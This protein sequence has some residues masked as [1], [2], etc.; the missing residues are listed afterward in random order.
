MFWITSVGAGHVL[1]HLGARLSRLGTLHI[2]AGEFADQRDIHA[3]DKP[4]LAG[5][6]GQRGGDADQIAALMLLE[7]ILAQVRP[8]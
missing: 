3:A 4:D 1:D 6:R 5:G 2:A 8:V 7:L